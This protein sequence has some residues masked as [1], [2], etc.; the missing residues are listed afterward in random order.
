MRE[1]E[2]EKKGPKGKLATVTNDG[3]EIDGEMVSVRI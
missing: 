1:R 2:K 3:Q